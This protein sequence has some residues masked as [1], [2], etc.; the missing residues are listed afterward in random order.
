MTDYI[1]LFKDWVIT[2]GEKHEVDPLLLGSLYLISKLSFFTFLGWVLKN[3]RAKNRFLFRYF[4]PVLVLAC[5][6]FTS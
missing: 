3:L 2:L 4:L 6:I 1:T 5:P